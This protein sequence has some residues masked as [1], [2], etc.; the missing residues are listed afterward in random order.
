MNALSDFESIY[1]SMQRPKAMVLIAEKNMGSKCESLPASA[2]AIM[3][4]LEERKFEM[5]DPEVAKHVTRDESARKAIEQGNAPAV[6]SLAKS[7]GAEILVIGTAS[8]A[9]QSLPD[10]LGDGIKAASALLNVRIVYADTGE[11]LFTSG[12]IDGRGVSTSTAIDAGTRALDDA[13]SK[14][15]SSDS[16]RFTSQVIARWAAEVQNGRTYKVIINGVTYPEFEAMKKAISEFRGHVKFAE[17]IC[18]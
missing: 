18:G 15:I 14:L 13:G 1:A 4:V 2:A 8:A 10:T 12:Q 11:V 17:E 6:S 16:D 9:Q 7:E 3:R 5:V